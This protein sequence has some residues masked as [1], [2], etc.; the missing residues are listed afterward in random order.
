MYNKEDFRK[1]IM[2][3]DKHLLIMTMWVYNFEQM[4]FMRDL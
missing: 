2:K 3:V 4:V 1:K